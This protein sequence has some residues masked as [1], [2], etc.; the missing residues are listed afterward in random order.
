MSYT[1]PQLAIP[2]LISFF[3]PS[4]IYTRPQLAILALISFFNWLFPPIWAILSLNKQFPLKW[5]IPDTRWSNLAL[6]S[7]YRP[8]WAI[9]ALMGH[10]VLNEQL[11]PSMSCTHPQLA[12]STLN[13]LFTPLITAFIR[14]S[15]SLFSNTTVF[16]FDKVCSPWW[17]TSWTSGSGRSLSQSLLLGNPRP[18]SQSG[19]IIS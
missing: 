4:M 11:P 19:Q 16:S 2:A 15:R 3:P 13:E 10:S 1:R 5:A 12:I 17:G 6:I 14:C 18:M 9:P 7:F 8:Q